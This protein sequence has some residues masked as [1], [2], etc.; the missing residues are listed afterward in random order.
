MTYL[1]IYLR[2]LVKLGVILLNHLLGIC[3]PP[4]ERMEQ[5]GDGEDGRSE[6]R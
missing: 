4:R 2:S 1:S 5:G 3:V 6:A